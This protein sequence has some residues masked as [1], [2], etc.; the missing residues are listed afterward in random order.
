M[1]VLRALLGSGRI[2]STG[3]R[4]TFSPA[5]DWIEA[6]GGVLIM[7]P[8]IAASLLFMPRPFVASRSFPTH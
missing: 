5:G 1:N 2:S 8:K 7:P 4:S 6:A 3:M